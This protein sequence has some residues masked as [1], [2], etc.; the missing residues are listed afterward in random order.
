MSEFL[1]NFRSTHSRF[2]GN[3]R[4]PY[5]GHYYPAQDRRIGNDRRNE[6][7]QTQ[8]KP[9]S[10]LYAKI[11]DFLPTLQTLLETITENQQSLIDLK[12][13]QAASGEEMASAF[14]AIAALLQNLHSPS[15]KPSPLETKESDESQS[16]LT[17]EELEKTEMKSSADEKR[18]IIRIMKKLRKKGG[19]YKE[20]AYFLNENKIPTFS[21]KG[22]WHAQTIHRLCSR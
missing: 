6:Q 5:D 8:G 19:T 15:S 14:K 4:N 10:S 2:A 20:I 13:S 17:V 1:K 3:K 9:T 7:A 11:E 16:S 12:K 22:H 21:N 18:D